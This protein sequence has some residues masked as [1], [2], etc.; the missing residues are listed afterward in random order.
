VYSDAGTVQA[1]DTPT[2]KK[3]KNKK[4]HETGKRVDFSM[5]N[6]PTL[7]FGTVGSL[8]F[9]ARAES[10]TR[11]PTTTIGLDATQVSWQSP[12]IGV[13]GGFF[14]KKLSF[15]VSRDPSE[16][17]EPWK[18]VYINLRPSRSF[19]VQ[20][21]RFKL[22]FGREMLTGRSN[23]DFAYRSLASTVL[24]PSRDV[25]MMAHGRVLRKMLQ[26]EAGY[27]VHDGDNART[28][29][30]EAAHATVGGRVVLLPFLSSPASALSGLEVGAAFTTSDLQNQLGLRGST[31]FEDGVF[32]DRVFVNGRRQRT[33]FEA[34]WADGPVSLSAE[35]IL[36][37]DQRKGMGFS[38][39]DL[40]G[41]HSRGWYVAGTWALT[42]EKKDG[43]L[44]P[45]RPFLQHGIGALE[46]AARVEQ[47]EF[48]SLSLPGNADFAT[49]VGLNW[50]LNRY[51]KVQPN[52]IIESVRDPERSPA[53]TAAGRFLSG[54]I[55][56]QLVL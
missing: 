23:L 32:F 5:A 2:P 55:R 28:K 10:D 4:K 34:A 36:A 43:R 52:L 3:K 41:V 25:G 31:V 8:E 38:D 17:D 40:P 30:A 49:T 14:N 53:P 26:Y 16:G 21:G 18:D 24:S 50:Y 20:A 37:S 48:S 33:G 29:H 15:E 51:I 45:R 35:F 1:Q 7:T 22:P 27:F 39:E 9:E 56:L 13:S 12:R 44:K 47:L 42:G 11:T 19:E 6:H 54:V 46:L